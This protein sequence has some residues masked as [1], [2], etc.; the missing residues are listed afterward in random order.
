EIDQEKLQKLNALL[1]AA[2]GVT[3]VYFAVQENGR[4]HTIKTNKKILIHNALINFIEDN[5]PPEPWD[6]E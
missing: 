6:F 1:D 2:K 3:A 4:T 5:F